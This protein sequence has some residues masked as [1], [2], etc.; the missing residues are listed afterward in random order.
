MLDKHKISWYS[1]L[2]TTKNRGFDKIAK[3]NSVVA[4]Q[5]KTD[6]VAVYPRQKKKPKKG[7]RLW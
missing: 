4:T 3:A 7:E 2:A 5:R 6:A 1:I